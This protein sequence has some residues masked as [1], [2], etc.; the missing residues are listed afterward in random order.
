MNFEKF[1]HRKLSFFNIQVVTDSQ[2]CHNPR[3]VLEC[4]EQH[5]RDSNVAQTLSAQKD[6]KFQHFMRIV[7]CDDCENW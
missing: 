7:I 2:N 4:Y 5:Q 3:Q 1:Y 6:L